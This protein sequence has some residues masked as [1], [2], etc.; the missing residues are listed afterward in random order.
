MV[1]AVGASGA[2]FAD[3]S[4]KAYFNALFCFLI[5][6]M[7]TTEAIKKM[8]PTTIKTNAQTG[9]GSLLITGQRIAA[10]RLWLLMGYDWVAVSNDD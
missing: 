6:K 3:F 1:T 10:A 8:P 7:P 9:K 2:S 4:S 5:I